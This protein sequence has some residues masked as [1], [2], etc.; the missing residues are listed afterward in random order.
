M[1]HCNYCTAKIILHGKPL[2]DF[3]EVSSTPGS[4]RLVAAR[5]AWLI[6][7]KCLWNA[8]PWSRSSFGSKNRRKKKTV[9]LS[10]QYMIHMVNHL[11]A[12]ILHVLLSLINHVFAG[13]NH[14]S[15]YWWNFQI[16]LTKGKQVLKVWKLSISFFFL[17]G[18]HCCFEIMFVYLIGLGFLGGF[19]H[20]VL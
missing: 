12:V 19:A 10:Q 4:R 18:G 1:P 8:P 11:M 3:N 14:Y 9:Y 16:V 15:N 2:Q 17:L 20:N 5:N 6:P 13:H 7:K